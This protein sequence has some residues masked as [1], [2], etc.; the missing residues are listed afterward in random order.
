[1]VVVGGGGGSGVVAGIGISGSGVIDG[2]K[3]MKKSR[4]ETNGKG[5][6]KIFNVLELVEK[7][8]E[9]VVGGV[10]DEGVEEVIEEKELSKMAGGRLGGG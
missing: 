2:G 9:G 7:V 4:D 3:K 8:V 6:E 1:M 5:S 10:V